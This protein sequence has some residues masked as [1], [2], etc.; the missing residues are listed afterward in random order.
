MWGSGGMKEKERILKKGSLIKGI[1]GLNQPQG[2][3]KRPKFQ[4]PLVGFPLDILTDA[5][6]TQ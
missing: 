6:T 1:I 4:F 5:C 2:W 3:V